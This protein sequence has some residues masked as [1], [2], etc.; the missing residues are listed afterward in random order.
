MFWEMVEKAAPNL[1]IKQLKETLKLKEADLTKREQKIALE[2]QNLVTTKQQIAAKEKSLSEKE[3]KLEGVPKV[4]EQA[5]VLKQKEAELVRLAEARGRQQVI[6][7]YDNKRR[8][9]RL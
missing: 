8:Q 9:G 2:E 6:D 1:S 5:R 4:G 7:E 3:A